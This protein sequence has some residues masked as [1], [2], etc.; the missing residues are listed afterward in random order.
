MTRPAFPGCLPLIVAI[1]T[2]AHTEGIHLSCDGH[3]LDRPV[4]RLAGDPRTDV[5]FMGEVDEIGKVMHLDP[6]DGFLGV[7]VLE[8]DFNAGF[9][10]CGVFVTAHALPFG[11]DPGNDRSVSEGV[12]VHAIHL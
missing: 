3:F 11:G 4:A 12:A 10:L 1:Q 8:E 5:P 9:F 2:P 6:F 7:P